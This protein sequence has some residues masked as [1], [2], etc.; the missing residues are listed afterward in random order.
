MT[1]TTA[2]TKIEA[3]FDELVPSAGKA[4]T[5]AGEIIRAISRISYRRFNDG[6]R[7]GVGY[8]KETCNAAARYLAEN[9]GTRVEEAVN[10][11]WGEGLESRY[12]EGLTALEEAVVAFIEEHPELKT[13]ENSKDMWDYRDDA[14]DVDD[15]DE[16]EE[17]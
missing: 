13:T 2:G 12:D 5:V 10:A 8:G 14:E 4:D 7:I 11:I 15:Y 6:D 1:M 9:C 16:E 3:M 17:W